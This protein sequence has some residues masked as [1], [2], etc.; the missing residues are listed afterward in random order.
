MSWALLYTLMDPSE[1]SEA[2][3]KWSFFEVPV[4][5]IAFVVINGVLVPSAEDSERIADLGLDGS[6]PK[7]LEAGP[8]A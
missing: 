4:V 3:L 2:S 1:P 8:W 5:V 6:I 7:G